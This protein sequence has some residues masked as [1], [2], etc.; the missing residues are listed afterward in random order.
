MVSCISFVSGLV[1]K[2][3]KK[4][5][6]FKLLKSPILKPESFKAWITALYMKLF[7]LVSPSNSFSMASFVARFAPLQ[8]PFG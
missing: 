5:S 4:K 7:F 3:S 2:E 8:S 6:Q 1:F